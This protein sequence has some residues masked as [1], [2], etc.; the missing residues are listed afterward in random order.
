M[1]IQITSRHKKAST[2]LQEAIMAELG[3]LEKY[4]DKITTCHVVLDTERDS[5]VVEI[6]VQTMHHTLVSKT[7]SD[8][9]GKALD[10]AVEKIERQIKKINEK[11]KDHKG[12]GAKELK[13]HGAKEE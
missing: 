9:V 4:N 2:Q 7:K 11:I 5:K 1:E 10:E 13:E 12:T 8:N 3:K 6:T